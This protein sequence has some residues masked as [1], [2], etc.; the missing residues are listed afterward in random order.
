MSEVGWLCRLHV[1]VI[2]VGDPA[3]LDLQHLIYVPMA[4]IAPEKS[5][6][7]YCMSSTLDLVRG[8]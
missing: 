6:S 1:T 5:I 7:A 2:T 3:E 4:I 8:Q